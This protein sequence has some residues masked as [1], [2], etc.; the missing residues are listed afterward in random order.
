MIKKTIK[1]LKGRL[2]KIRF[3]KL[4]KNSTLSSSHFNSLTPSED[5]ENCEVY[6]EA[7]EWAL[8]NNHNIKNIALSGP[9]GSGKSSILQTFIKQYKGKNKGFW[10]WMLKSLFP[11]HFPKYRFLNL[12]LATFK[13]FNNS[14][15]SI[16][17]EEKSEAFVDDNKPNSSVGEIFD[18]PKN[19]GN[20]KI[21]NDKNISSDLKNDQDFQRLIELSILQQLFYHEND[22]KIPD[23]R[24]K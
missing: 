10:N 5:A 21:H 6:F 11:K 18:Q 14:H 8:K 16:I 7:L 17:E 2:N 24:F 4:T 15:Q 20:T 19:G 22:K 9:F 13:H 23:S 3:K 12:S 1:I